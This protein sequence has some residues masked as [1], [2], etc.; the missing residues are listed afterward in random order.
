VVTIGQGAS[1]IEEKIARDGSAPPLHF[2]G[3]SLAKVSERARE[4][5]R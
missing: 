2:F 5:Q 4:D 1:L 3:D